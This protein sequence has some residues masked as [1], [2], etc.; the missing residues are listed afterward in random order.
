[1]SVWVTGPR[2]RRS[3]KSAFSSPASLNRLNG[4][5]G[6]LKNPEAWIPIKAYVN[7][8]KKTDMNHLLKP[9]ICFLT[10]FLTLTLGLLGCN[11]TDDSGMASETQA[12]RIVHPVGG[13]AFK[14]NDTVQI[15]VESDYTRFGGGVS[16]DYSPDT[17]KT[18]YL[19]QSFG[20]KP[21]VYRD[22]LQWLAQE[23][24]DVAN[25]ATILLRAYDYE[26]DFVMTLTEG[27]RFSD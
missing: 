21:G 20:R 12:V 6:G 22:T 11:S 5:R 14:V 13:Q 23:T 3:S 8:V 17:S 4:F 24:G 2:C 9:F 27:I 16:V 26:K 19:I 10:V 18:W 7:L 15:I 25:G 1:M